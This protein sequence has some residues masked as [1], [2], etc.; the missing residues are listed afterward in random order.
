MRYELSQ[1]SCTFGNIYLDTV[2]L[3]RKKG[4]IVELEGKSKKETE[5]LYYSKG[6]IELDSLED[7]NKLSYTLNSSSPETCRSLVFTPGRIIIYDD[8]IE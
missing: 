5:K 3:L 2:Q 7:L 8:Y 1:A 6:F 4:F